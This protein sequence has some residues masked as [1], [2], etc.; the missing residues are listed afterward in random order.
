MSHGMHLIIVVNIFQFDYKLDLD[1]LIKINI[2]VLK[3]NIKRFGIQTIIIFL[4]NNQ[5]LIDI[6]QIL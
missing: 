2:F 6:C 4:Y 3:N 1:S 5:F